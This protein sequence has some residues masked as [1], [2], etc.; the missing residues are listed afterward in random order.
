VFVVATAGHVDHGKSTLVRRLTGMEPDRW[1]EERRR[2]LTIDLG[3]AW[4]TFGA[5]EI[6][7]VD[8]PGHER[9]VPNMLAGVGP[10]PAVMFV[11]AADEGWMR[12][13]AEH[14]A[15]LN[16]LGVRHGLLVVTKIDRADPAAATAQALE[17]I[18]G[19]TL[20]EVPA[21]T[22]SGHTGDG[23]AQLRQELCALVDRLPDPDRAADV[24]L[25]VD[26][27]FTIRG[28][29]TVVTGTLTGGTV[30]VGDA[31]T[32]AA[33]GEP[34]RV[35]GLQSLG[36]DE[37][38]VT[39]VARVAV[40]LRGPGLA[41]LGRGDALLTPD[42]WLSTAELDVLLRGDEAGKLHRELV[43]H[44]GAAAVPVRVRPLGTD[45]ARLTAAAP[46]PLRVGDRGLLRDPGEHRVPAGIEV[47]DV[48]PPPLNRRGAP[49]A[50]AA[51]LASG[52]FQRRGWA[53]AT[54]LRA[55][56][57]PVAGRRIGAWCVD[58]A[59]W[60]AS[61]REALVRFDGWRQADSLAAGLP[62]EALRK[63]LE[64][65]AVEIVP[66]LLAGTG[67]EIIDGL[68][69]RPGV[70]LPEAVHKA[71]R[72]LEG[73]FAGQPFR[74]PEAD[75]L[76]ALGLGAREL[77]AAERAGRLSRIADG[78]VL[79]PDAVARAAELLA[80]L[81]DAFTVSEARQAL[82]TTRRV[83]V[84]L[85]EKLHAEGVTERLA[86]GRHRRR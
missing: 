39:A 54:E 47:V 4:T 21:V 45:T 83:A 25:W 17:R 60:A 20:G 38:E 43:L 46:L 72:V 81:G 86:D 9:F 32:I 6:A 59:T 49:A 75:E 66:E 12:Q 77:A 44:I 33:T 13:S 7:F 67:L 85:L 80:G 68:V 73:R 24:R 34:V 37:P 23:V 29:G 79:G 70:R 64:L 30:R 15:A 78:I 19:T 11:V 26:R 36:R 8:V 62:V 55:M 65:P 3:F 5:G 52:R 22:V 42:S 16:A 84:P 14:L 58:E 40:N 2:G 35:R 53:R 18:A 31:L 1:A 71:L 51:E 56:G 28:A 27:V 41:R 74:A 48:R 69:R 50:R 63:K 10:A 76:T 61:R 57:L 82:G